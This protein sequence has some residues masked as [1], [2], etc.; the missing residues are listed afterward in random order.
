MNARIHT[1]EDKDALGKDFPK[2]RKGKREM[3]ETTFKPVILTVVNGLGLNFWETS[4]SLFSKE[5]P[6]L[7][8]LNSEAEEASAALT[9]LKTKYKDILIEK[10][11]IRKSQGAALAFGL[12][13]AY[14]LGF[15]HAITVQD[16][17]QN[18]EAI[19]VLSTA[20]KCNPDSFIC[21]EKNDRRRLYPLK[22]TVRII[23]EHHLGLGFESEFEKFFKGP[24]SKIKAPGRKEP[25]SLTE[26]LYASLLR[27][28]KH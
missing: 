8:L 12:K 27:L 18:K 3:P 11:G 6:T 15:T 10:T 7:F 26:T 25:V 14:E 19:K 17:S 22:S 9:L 5:A 20:G 4:D 21:G 28:L 13:R 23:E 24:R 1:L 2:E 16:L